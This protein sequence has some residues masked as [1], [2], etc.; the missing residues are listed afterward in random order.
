MEYKFKYQT[1]YWGRGRYRERASKSS[2]TNIC[3]VGECV[4]KGQH[5]GAEREYVTEKREREAST[6]TVSESQRV[7]ERVK[8]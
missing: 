1:I 6:K 2:V 5:N 3:F 7:R 4:M 8:V